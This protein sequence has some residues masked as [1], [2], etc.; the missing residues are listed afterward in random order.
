MWKTKK[1]SKTFIEMVPVYEELVSPKKA[2]AILTESKSEIESI[3]F[4]LPS[5]NSDNFG[6]FQIK[7]KN[8][9]YHKLNPENV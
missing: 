6:M 3:R 2:I 4:Q 8:P 7:W 9:Q 5:I 1:E